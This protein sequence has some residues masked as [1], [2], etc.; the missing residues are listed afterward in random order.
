MS[1]AAATNDH[2]WTLARDGSVYEG[3]S[4]D[5]D[6]YCP[7]NCKRPLVAEIGMDI[8]GNT[9]IWYKT[10]Y[11]RR[12]DGTLYD[13]LAGYDVIERGY[14]HMPS[15]QTGYT[16][17]GADLAPVWM[18]ETALGY[19]NS[20]GTFGV[21]DSLDSG[22]LPFT[23]T[24][25]PG[26]SASTLVGLAVSADGSVYSWYANQT[27]AKGTYANLGSSFYGSSFSLPAGQPVQ[28]IR[29][30][31]IN[32]AVDDRVW[33]LYEDGSVSKGYTNNIGQLGYWPAQ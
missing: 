9:W 7:N 6:S 3:W 16:V 29:G 15:N 25:P 22:D 4:A 33:V 28:A 14:Y 24:Y 18:G 8:E 32:W 20:G 21:G 30:I 11:Y 17:V 1:I 23:P 2:V 19:Y 26:Q 13:N 10:G 27:R 12:L 31:A 5:L